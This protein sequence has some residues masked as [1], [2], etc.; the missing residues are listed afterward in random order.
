LVLIFDQ[1]EATGAC[2]QSE[3]MEKLEANPIKALRS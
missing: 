3:V 2:D 1:S